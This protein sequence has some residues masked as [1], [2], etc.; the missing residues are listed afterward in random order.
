MEHGVAE[1]RPRV[2]LEADEAVELEALGCRAR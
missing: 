1:D 2:V